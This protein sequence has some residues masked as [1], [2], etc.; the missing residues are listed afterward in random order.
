MSGDAHVRAQSPG[1][2]EAIERGCIC[3]PVEN[4][5]GEGRRGASGIRLFVPDDECPLHGLNATFGFK[6]VS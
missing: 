1:A 3:D 6:G 5:Q 2:R 4:W